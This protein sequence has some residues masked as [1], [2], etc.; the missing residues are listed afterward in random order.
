MALACRRLLRSPHVS[1]FIKPSDDLL[2]RH[3]HT[4]EK[5]EGFHDY[6]GLTEAVSIS[7]LSQS[8]PVGADSHTYDK[9]AQKWTEF[10]VEADLADL[11]NEDTQASTDRAHPC[12]IYGLWVLVNALSLC[13]HYL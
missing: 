6:T 10:D 11:S 5:T 12:K 8:G 1:T 4:R 13:A 2:R 9:A 7:N 3:E